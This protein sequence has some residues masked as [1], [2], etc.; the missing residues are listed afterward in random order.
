MASPV[1]HKDL[2]DLYGSGEGA[3]ASG[4]HRV[5]EAQRH[6]DA[7][8]SIRG[9]LHKPELLALVRFGRAVVVAVST[10]V[11]EHS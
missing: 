8:P 6:D 10:K 3:S 9:D 11:V 5:V 7:V 4:A 2:S 1:P